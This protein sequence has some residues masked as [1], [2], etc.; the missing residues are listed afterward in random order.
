MR[1]V[2]EANHRWAMEQGE[3]S[4]H[5][6]LIRYRARTPQDLLDA[7]EPRG[8]VAV[9]VRSIAIGALA[10]SAVACLAWIYRR[11]RKPQVAGA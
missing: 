8:P 1:P 3:L 5:E 7:A 2:F 9:P 11:S 4:L 6:E 10:I